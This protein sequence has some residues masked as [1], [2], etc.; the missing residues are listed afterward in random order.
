MRPRCSCESLTAW[1]ETITK[2]SRGEQTRGTLPLNLLSLLGSIGKGLES[3][4]LIHTRDFCD[5][6]CK[7]QKRSLC[8]IS[9]LF[10]LMSLVLLSNCLIRFIHLISRLHSHKVHCIPTSFP[11][12]CRPAKLVNYSQEP[13]R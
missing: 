8:K 3:A 5:K 2:V 13:G 7:Q 12:L 11:D 1:Q 10:Y 6:S 4:K 9:E